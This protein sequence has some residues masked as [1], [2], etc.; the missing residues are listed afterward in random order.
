MTLT[1]FSTRHF[2]GDGGEIDEARRA[3][4]IE[5]MSSKSP[6]HTV[7]QPIDQALLVAYLVSDAAR[8]ITG[9]VIRANGG[10]SM[11]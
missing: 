3:E 10:W 6:L 8:F 5:T 4:W 2:T 7:G 11:S 1:P 9:Q